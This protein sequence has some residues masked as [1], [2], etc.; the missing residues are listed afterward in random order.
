M[1]KEQ[2]KLFN[3]GDEKCRQWG[4]EALVSYWLFT[5]KNACPETDFIEPIDM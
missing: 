2:Y 3:K 5:F 4:S 1:L